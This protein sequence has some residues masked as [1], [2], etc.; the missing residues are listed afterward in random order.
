MLTTDYFRNEPIPATML[1]LNHF[2][3]CPII[4][5]GFVGGDDTAR[6]RGLSHHLARP[7]FVEQLIFGDYALTLVEQIHQDIK[8]SGFGRL[9]Y[10][11]NVTDRAGRRVH[12]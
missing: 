1:S 5:Y 11:H 4:A 10:R 8:H 12:N 6:E 9:A 2:L 7:Q 3:F